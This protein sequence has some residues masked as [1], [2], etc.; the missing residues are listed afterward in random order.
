[1]L[2]GNAF[3]VA[4]LL[5]PLHLD[6]VR[7]R[8]DLPCRGFSS[9]VLEPEHGEERD[10]GCKPAPEHR[11]PLEVLPESVAL[12]PLDGFA[13]VIVPLSALVEV[14]SGAALVVGVVVGEEVGVTASYGGVGLGYVG[15]R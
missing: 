8:R 3:A 4:L 12:V 14:Y 11:V 6:G 10:E 2:E 13:H 7:Y 9:R 5:A 1:M 15:E